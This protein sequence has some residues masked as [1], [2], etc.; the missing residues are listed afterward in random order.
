MRNESHQ[1]NKFKEFLRKTTVLA[2][3]VSGM[4][5]LTACAPKNIFGQEVSVECGTVLTQ[6]INPGATQIFFPG[7][8]D[9]GVEYKNGGLKPKGDFYIDPT[10]GEIVYYIEDINGDKNPDIAKLY[11]TDNSVTAEYQCPSSSTQ[12]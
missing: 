5:A 8:I 11:A 7:G 2:L 1:L 4:L 3:I 9:I 10:T 12:E 6:Q